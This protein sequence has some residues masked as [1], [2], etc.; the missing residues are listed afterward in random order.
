MEVLEPDGLSEDGD[1]TP[2]H[3]TPF[4]LTSYTL[5][6][7]A[8]DEVPVSEVQRY[9]AQKKTPR[10]RT[11]QQAYAYDPTIVLDGDGREEAEGLEGIPGGVGSVA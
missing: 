9:L 2:L 1:R 11:L 6:G 3:S 7:V 4:T 5:Y 10:P 8:G